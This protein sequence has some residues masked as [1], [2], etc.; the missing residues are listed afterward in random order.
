MCAYFHPKL[1]VTSRNV[2]NFNEIAFLLVFIREAYI[3]FG[4]HVNHTKNVQY[5]VVCVDK[6]SISTFLF[7][8]LLT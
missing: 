8:I 3:L 4:L 7:K 6:S 1:S 2:V 5:A